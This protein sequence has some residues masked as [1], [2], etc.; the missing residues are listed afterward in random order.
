MAERDLRATVVKLLRALDAVAVENPAYPGTPDVNFVEGWLELKWE[1]DWPARG[2]ILHVPHFTQQQRVWLTRRRSRGGIAKVL[3]VCG[4]EWLLF[5]GKV[6]ANTLGR[7]G[8]EELMVAAE[9]HWPQKPDQEEF[10]QCV[11]AT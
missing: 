8:R 10:V 11:L 6:A 4:R 9:K 1:R 7:A 2:G 5:D 3:L